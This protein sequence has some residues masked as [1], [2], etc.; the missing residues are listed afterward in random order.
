[1]LK[2]PGR[3]GD[4]A[5]IDAGTY[6]DDGAG[7]VS[8]TGV[9][10]AFIRAAAAKHAIEA[11]RAGRSGDEAAREVLALVKRH[12]GNGGL[13]WIDATGRIG[14]AF[15]TARMPHAWIA[16]DGRPGSNEAR[17]EGSGFATA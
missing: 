5:L 14:A 3:V 2:R 9:G 10:E 8:G 1:M 6:A 12:G 11:M 13:I 17:R 4:S 15:D 16:G 7:A